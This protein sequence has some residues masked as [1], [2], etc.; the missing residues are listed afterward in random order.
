VSVTVQVRDEPRD[1]DGMLT[2]DAIKALIW[3][4]DPVGNELDLSRDADGSWSIEALRALR[5]A[6]DIASEPEPEPDIDLGLTLDEEL[7]LSERLE[8]E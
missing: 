2:E 1:P 8:R 6:L 3:V 7:A 4:L 5:W